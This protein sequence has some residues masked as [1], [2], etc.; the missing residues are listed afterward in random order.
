MLSSTKKAALKVLTDNATDRISCGAYN[1]SLPFDGRLKSVLGLGDVDVEDVLLD[2]L[3]EPIREI[4]SNPGKG[5]RGKLVTLAYRLVNKE[6]QFYTM[7]ARKLE[8]GAG[9]LELIHAGSLIVDDIEDA[10]R[11]RRGRPAMHV[12]YGLPIAL[13]AGNWLYFWP[14]QLVKDLGLPSDITLAAYECYHRTLL[15]AHFGQAMDIGTRVDR[16]AQPRVGEVCL[17]S[18][19]LKTGA[20]TGFA[21]A[22]GGL[23]AGAGEPATALLDEFGCDLG[24][25][26]QMFDDLGNLTGVREPTKR[27]EDLMAYRPSWAWACA[28]M[29]SSPKEYSQFVDA[30]KLLPQAAEV[31]AWIKRHDL[32]SMGRASAQRQLDQAFLKLER[33]LRAQELRWSKRAFEELRILGDEIAFAYA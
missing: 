8:I 27:Y 16:L 6:T 20:L 5:I 19:T 28:A 12:R 26:L 3:I 15:K 11:M 14:F 21:M 10:S 25:A 17:A 22:M 7:A 24:V 29:N 4:I 30:V 31:E 32:I 23:I 33:G 9:V 18:L 2:A 13:N 1:G